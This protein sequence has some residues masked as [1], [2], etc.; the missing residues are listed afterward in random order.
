MRRLAFSC[1]VGSCFLMACA[2]AKFAPIARPLGYDAS[3]SCTPRGGA[4]SD[5]ALR[6]SGELARTLVVD[7][8]ATLE[9][10]F[11]EKHR[12]FIPQERQPLQR[13]P[14]LTFPALV[15]PEPAR[16]ARKSASWLF[17]FVID[18]RQL[19]DIPTDALTGEL[20]FWL[21]P[22]GADVA[23][24]RW[25][26]VTECLVR[27][28]ARDTIFALDDD[29]QPDRRPPGAIVPTFARR[30]RLRGVVFEI[31]TRTA[32]AGM[33]VA[34]GFYDLRALPRL[35]ALRDVTIGTPALEQTKAALQVGDWIR[36]LRA[37]RELDPADLTRDAAGDLRAMAAQSRPATG[38][39]RCIP[40]RTSISTFRRCATCWGV[41]PSSS[42]ACPATRLQCSSPSRASSS[43]CDR[44]WWRVPRWRP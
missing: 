21:V 13:F 38:P 14:R 15:D 7:S 40:R 32:A 43:P 41:W 31:P 26:D 17:P 1:V 4:P 28:D 11:P 8:L 37:V 18:K 20:R 39:G 44:S 35:N 2:T 42:S 29:R 23:T 5:A 3:G 12:Q 16:G 33:E 6:E 9:N 36:A 34:P 22:H 24:A 30:D 19:G 25:A 10:E 27:A